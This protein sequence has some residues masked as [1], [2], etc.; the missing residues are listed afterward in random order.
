MAHAPVSPVPLV[1]RPW[2]LTRNLKMR[3]ALL[4]HD[5]VRCLMASLKR[6]AGAYRLTL[7]E[8]DSQLTFMSK[9]SKHQTHLWAMTLKI[10]SYGHPHVSLDAPL[11][12][13]CWK[14]DV[15]IKP[16]N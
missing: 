13:G 5:E 6:A 12:Q 1:A 3:M 8:P 9:L 11:A 10:F 2:R 14:G 4:P 16:S 7:S 15:E